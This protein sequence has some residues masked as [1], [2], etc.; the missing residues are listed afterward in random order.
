M[1]F[2]FNLFFFFSLMLSRAKNVP[3]FGLSWILAFSQQHFQGQISLEVLNNRS[4]M[5][6]SQEILCSAMKCS[7]VPPSTNLEYNFPNEVSLSLHSGQKTLQNVHPSW[8]PL[9]PFLH[10]GLSGPFRDT[11]LARHTLVLVSTL[12]TESAKSSLLTKPV[13]KLCCVMLQTIGLWG[14]PKEP[15]P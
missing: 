11:S 4:C 3:A 1:S 9:D 13:M 5:L 14:A 15:F 8:W 7:L 6:P 10:W 2:L 12:G